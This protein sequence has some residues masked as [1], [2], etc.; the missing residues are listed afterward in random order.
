V[1]GANLYLN[2][3]SNY[4]EPEQLAYPVRARSDTEGRFEFRFA[5]TELDKARSDNPRVQVMAVAKG[6]GFDLAN[7]GTDGKDGELTLR[8]VEDT[9]VVG[10]IIDQEGR[11]VPG[12]TVRV[13]E[14][15][16]FEGG[17]KELTEELDAIRARAYGKAPPE[18]GWPGPFPGHLAPIKTAADG[19]FRLTGLGR[20]R[21][22]DL[23]V[24]GPDIEYLRIRV[25]TRPGMTIDGPPHSYFLWWKRLYGATFD[26]LAAPSRPIRGVVCD[27]QT[28]K[29]LAGIQISGPTTHQTRTDKDGRYELLG[30]AKAKEYTVA[31][32][33]TDG[34]AFIS[35]KLSVADTPGLGPLDV[36]DIQLVRGVA[37]R[38]R[39]T[40]KETG[41]PIKGASITYYPIRPNP[42]GKAGSQTTTGS[43]GAFALVALPG[44]GVLAV[45]LPSRVKSETNP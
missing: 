45:G 27:K 5:K 24:E 21:M 11:P 17:A 40:D 13:I 34:P 2:Y 22:A 19:K 6:Y 41:K 37:V 23:I 39:L 38:G 10:R 9:P 3:W 31:A 28:G 42:Y 26:H 33:S 12:A 30:C 18:K 16:A 8:L 15:V 32:R 7:L 35:G 1:A 29:P 4:R 44:P 20:D 36:A 14:V 43:D 25:T